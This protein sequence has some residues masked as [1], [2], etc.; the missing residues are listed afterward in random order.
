MSTSIGDEHDDRLTQLSAKAQELAGRVAGPLRRINIQLDGAAVELEWEE[1][2]DRSTPTTARP[3]GDLAL[4]PAPPE[5]GDTTAAVRTPV[6]GTFYR[7]Q[8]PGEAPFVAVGATVSP[9]TV[10]GI[11]E[12]M[13]LMN[14]IVA[15][16]HG[17]VRGVLPADG[18]PVEFDEVLVEL[19]PAP[20]HDGEEG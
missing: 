11:V 9:D 18:S 6:V 2:T 16:Q 3:M 15:G 10:V 1:G 7:A 8:A 13:K 12:A 19:D 5:A 4:A 20:G 14:R 17:V